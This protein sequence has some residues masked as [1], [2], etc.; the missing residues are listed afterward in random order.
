MLLKLKYLYYSIF[1]LL[2]CSILGQNISLLHQYNGKYDFLFIGNT[3]N[4]IENNSIPGQP[5][6]PCTILT[7][8]TATL[9]LNPTDVVENAYLYWAGSGTGD[10]DVKLNGQ[11]ITP[12]RTFSI[13]N[14]AGLPCFSAFKDVTAQVLATGN[15]SYTLSDLDLSGIIADYC[16]TGGNFAGWAIVIIY[17]NNA[18][19]I[20]QVN[21]YDGMQAVPTAIDIHLDS[22]NVIDNLGAK[23]GFVA[24][25][26]D[27]NIA[28]NET[29]SINGHV[30]S[31]PPLNPADNCFNGTNSFTGSDTLYNMD[32]DVYNIQNNINVGDTTAL[33]QLTSGQ[34]FVMVNTVVT[35][36]N[37]QLPD[38]TIAINQVNLNCNSRQIPTQ[39]TVF[40]VN[41][42]D[43]LPAHTPIAIY[44]N[45]ILVGTT[46]TNAIIPI[47]GSENGSITLTIPTGIPDGFTL[48]FSVDDVGNGTGIVPEII[49]NNNT[50]STVVQLL[51]PPLF[52]PLQNITQ[53]VTAIATAVFD[54][55][56]YATS[57]KVNPT[58]VVSFF[59]TYQNAFDNVNPI[60][61]PSSYTV[62]A[63]STTLFVRIDNGSCFSITSFM[64]NLVLYPAYNP[65]SPLYTCKETAASAFDFSGYVHLVKVNPTDVVAF[66]ETA[67]DANNATNPIANAANYIPTA[68]PKT[69]FVR[70]DNG[71]CFSVTSFS[72]LYYDLPEFNALQDLTSCNEGLT[73]GTFDFSGYEDLVKTNSS[74]GVRFFESS[75][76]AI[77]NTNPIMDAS[78][79]AASV[80]PKEIFVRITDLNTCYSITS[81]MLYTKNCPPVVFNAVSPNGDG[82]NDTFYIEGLRDVFVNFQLYIYNRWG[83]MVWEGNNNTPD[84]DGYAN[85]GFIVNHTDLPFGTYFY[86]LKLNDADYPAPLQGWLFLMK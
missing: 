16:P 1:L 47:G 8:S 45:G 42:T 41:C 52:H 21:I 61:T 55:S 29:L 27:K 34:D 49:E 76:D 11:A 65:L 13:I 77:N 3:M 63:A 24:W 70:V 43:V 28:V 19:P 35:K 37:S 51:N 15:G 81:F 73:K 54:F 72:L 80:T 36:L 44:A 4:I 78:H 17:K 69:I 71:F 84:F 79:Y 2:S 14:S 20:N 74:D 64:L 25:E 58:D 67:L 50:T 30:L 62:N 6:P 12:T 46:Q 56:S 57:V 7:S 60:A 86:I 22:L 59:A 82:M 75:Q 68:T 9:N 23:I 85:K 26:G 40:N 5:A 66:Y 53:C 48:T 33:I 18:L 38:A 32:L 83:Q 31:N 39:Y 10:F